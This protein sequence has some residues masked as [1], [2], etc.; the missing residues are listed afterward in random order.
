MVEETSKPESMPLSD[1]ELLRIRRIFERRETP[2]K[3]GEDYTF[4][5]DTFDLCKEVPKL[6]AEI[7]R[8][9]SELNK[10]VY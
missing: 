7:D 6:F 3:L 10:R 9:K 5:N 2:K 1:E 8:L 4:W